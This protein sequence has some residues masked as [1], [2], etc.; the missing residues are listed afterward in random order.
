NTY[1][2]TH[3]HTHTHTIQGFR[4]MH[5]S[6]FSSLS[7]FSPLSISLTLLLN[8]SLFLYLS[9]SF[10]FFLS[11]SQLC[12]REETEAGALFKYSIVCVYVCVF[13]CVKGS[14]QHPH[15]PLVPLLQ[16][17]IGRAH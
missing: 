2:L 16:S 4:N 11:L 5:A 1:T 13:V 6:T 8:S 10:S 7:L 9:L 12:I 17:E 15:L 14:L 3:T